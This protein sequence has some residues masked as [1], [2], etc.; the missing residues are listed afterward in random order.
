MILVMAELNVTFQNA[1]ARER[2]CSMERHR[3]GGGGERRR[4]R[5]MLPLAERS[6]YFTTALIALPRCCQSVRGKKTREV[7]PRGLLFRTE[8]WDS[9]NKQYRGLSVSGE[10][11][12]IFSYAWL[13]MLSYTP[14]W[15]A[16]KPSA[17]QWRQEMELL[18]FLG[19]CLCLLSGE[20]S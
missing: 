18:C 3:E 12:A 13:V 19:L 9:L 4:H 2:A 15:K 16:A 11:I 6:E 20:L 7:K 10:T 5:R 14:V 17:A 8:A 1:W